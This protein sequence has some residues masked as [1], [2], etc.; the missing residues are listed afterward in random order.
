MVKQ[1][2]GAKRRY[3]SLQTEKY[4]QK[5][6][7]FHVKHSLFYVVSSKQ[8]KT[9]IQKQAIKQSMGYKVRFLLTKDYILVKC[10]KTKK[11]TAQERSLFGRAEALCL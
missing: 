6:E 8:R 3:F 4:R 1:G 2:G 5:S 10:A 9:F 7:L 11:E